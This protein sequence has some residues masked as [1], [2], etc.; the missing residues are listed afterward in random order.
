MNN[1]AA[2]PVGSPW[3]LSFSV[4]TALQG[5][6]ATLDTPHLIDEALRLQEASMASPR[7][8]GSN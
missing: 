1:E 5:R 3:C 2:G 6:P 4:L 8:H 7:S